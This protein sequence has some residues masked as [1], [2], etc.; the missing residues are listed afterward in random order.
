MVA[1]RDRSSEAQRGLINDQLR[2]IERLQQLSSGDGLQSDRGGE[3][4]RYTV[5]KL[6]S[7]WVPLASPKPLNAFPKKRHC[8]PRSV[9]P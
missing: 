9:S 4:L 7:A 8:G 2:V 1:C 3:M 5:G 6:M